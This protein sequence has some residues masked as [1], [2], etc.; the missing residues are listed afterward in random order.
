L[1]EIAS[2]TRRNAENSEAAR[3]LAGEAR[4][5]AQLG[6]DHTQVMNETIQGILAATE[7]M[8]QAMAEI[9]AASGDISRIIRTID[10]I[11]FQTN[12]LSLNAAVEAARAGEAGAGFAVV[13]DEV[14]NLAQRSA[15]AAK[16]TEAIIAKAVSRSERG[17]QVNQ[18][19]GERAQ[20]VAAKASEVSAGLNEIVAKVRQVDEMVAGIAA[21]SKE[22]SSGIGQVTIAVSEMDKVTQ[23][24]AA[25][26]EESASAAS[27]LDSQANA[28]K[29][30]IS[31]LRGMVGGAGP[32]STDGSEKPSK[33]SALPVQPRDRIAPAVAVDR[34]VKGA[35]TSSR[36]PEAK[37][38]ADF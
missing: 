37:S 22:Q 21:A 36:H 16:E 25:N 9:Q 15:Q 28:L 30:S 6:S 38:L 14:R 34:F 11:A 3:A 33:I 19:V 23:A 35:P 4:K 26:A 13:A 32:E 27:E 2:M 18:R 20:A 29:D 12:I 10:E 17:A 8:K 5:S 1:E 31:Q 7:E 24:N